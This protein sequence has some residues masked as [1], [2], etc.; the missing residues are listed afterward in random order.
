MVNSRILYLFI[1][2]L[3]TGVTVNIS[4][5]IGIN[6]PQGGEIFQAGN[7]VTILWYILINYGSCNYDLLFPVMAE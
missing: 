4:A 7:V 1:F 5:N 3:T 6:N 2:S